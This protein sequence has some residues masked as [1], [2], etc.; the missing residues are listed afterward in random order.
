VATSSTGL[1]G[2]NTVIGGDGTDKIITGGG[3]DVL[4]GG[5]GSDFL[6]A[7][8]G[9]DIIIYDE[10][11]Y[12]ILGGGGV[13]TLW[14][15]AD[16]QSLDL[17]IQSVLGIEKL[18]MDESQWNQVWLSAADIIRVSDNDQ[19][20]VAGLGNNILWLTD[21]GWQFRGL[22]ADSQSQ[23]LTNGG[24][25][26]I[27][28]LP[29][30]VS[31]FSNNAN[32]TVVGTTVLTEDSQLPSSLLVA[33]GT[34]TVTDPNAG[35]G[36]LLDENASIETGVGVMQITLSQPW[37]ATTPAVYQYVYSTSNA[38]IQ[39]L[40][41]GESLDDTI[42]LQT[43]DGTG[44]FLS[45][46]I[47]GINDSA[48]I[49]D[50]DNASVTE[51]S[52]VNSEGMLTA[53][54]LIPI[55]DIDSDESAF[56]TTITAA[57]ENLGSLV[58]STD[59]SY[60]YAVS[61]AAVQYL[62]A[63]Q[64]KTELFIIS[65]IDGTT[66]EISFTIHG[67]SDSVSIGDPNIRTVTENTSVG[68]TGLLSVT[69]S[70][71]I[72]GPNPALAFFE[73]NVEPDAENLGTLTL[74]AIGN[75]TYTVEN[76][77]VQYLGNLEKKVD[78]FTITALDGTTKTISFE[79]DGIDNISLD[80][81]PS[82]GSIEEYDDAFSLEMSTIPHTISGTITGSNIAAISWI[83]DLDNQPY[84][85]NFQA[86]LLDAT[87]VSWH[88]EVADKYLDYLIGGETLVQNFIIT[89]FDAYSSIQKTV[90]IEL[91][92]T[93]DTP[94]SADPAY[95][96]SGN[97]SDDQDGLIMRGFGGDDGLIYSGSGGRI[98]GEDGADNLVL[99]CASSIIRGGD[100]DDVLEIT[101]GAGTGNEIYGDAGD[102]RFDF[103]VLNAQDIWG[104]PGTDTY[105]VHV[106][107]NSGGVPLIHDF[108]TRPPGE[109]GDLIVFSE[110]MINSLAQLNLT[111]SLTDPNIFV[112][113]SSG[114]ELLSF[115]GINL[116][117]PDLMDNLL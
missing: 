55:A 36:R 41:Q 98:Y 47:D 76:S 62:N 69:G 7:G 91:H 67:A 100:G 17:G 34:I 29:I 20:I 63:G 77:A 84:L 72:S 80:P 6:N 50:L 78:Y 116:T 71:P 75:Y 16:A 79:I 13:D 54:G 19:M 106:P 43:I 112:L 88:F 26:I 65:A 4:D 11:D 33:T 24:A 38:A 61:N 95:N 110:S 90:A 56:N 23:I 32:I 21:T 114:H 60:I 74:S 42:Y 31:G 51:D 57:A 40:R 81:S 22:T 83:A 85:G 96:L 37:S 8:G 12:K 58:L 48:L 115:V 1:G 105:V 89:A 97:F 45:F 94:F 46:S 9:N 86:I 14:F 93:D 39:M 10:Q 107:N 99:F 53:T 103:R 2:D 52:N 108:D 25:T 15:K 30:D 66:K 101:S 92:G 5:S 113:S 102:D 73:T 109:G 18:L 3:D 35:Q 117:L 27:V 44:A 59:G 104:G 82:S 64:S 87:T 68:P 49:G 28:S 111:N 70:I